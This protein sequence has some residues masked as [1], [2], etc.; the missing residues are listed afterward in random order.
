MVSTLA[1][2]QCLRGM[3]VVVYKVLLNLFSGS[4]DDGIHL[5]WK[6]FY[7]QHAPSREDVKIIQS[8]CCAVSE[9]AAIYIGV[10]L[11]TVWRLQ[12][13][14]MIADARTS[15]MFY[16]KSGSVA[17]A[18]CG[19]VVEKHP[20]LRRRSQ[21]ILDLLVDYESRR[22]QDQQRVL[23]L[24]EAGDSGLLGAGVASVMNA[25]DDEHIMRSR[26]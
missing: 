21:Q 22:G 23:V 20:S 13:D 15:E 25:V 24:E 3:F 12:R 6:A 26:L 2:W 14:K 10:T 8:I 4:V 11:F 1:I 17:I 16:K 7:C 19:T 9:R 5:I 18:Y